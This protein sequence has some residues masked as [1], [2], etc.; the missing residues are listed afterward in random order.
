MDRWYGRLT[1]D[2]LV[3]EFRDFKLKVMNGDIVFNITNDAIDDLSEELD[4][5][6]DTFREDDILT[7]SIALR[8]FGLLHR[9]SSDI[10]ILIKDKNRYSEYTKQ[11][12]GDME[13]STPNRLG[14]KIFKYRPNIFSKNKEYE[15][16]FFEDIE[17]NFTEIEVGDFLNSRYIRIHNPIEILDL[18]IKMAIEGKSDKHNEDL[19]RIF[20]GTPERI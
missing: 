8:L 20:I 2:E 3:R 7:G 17:S 6:K 1:P 15:V 5:I 4:F 14:Y 16:D 11:K 12:Y 10:D 9:E 18:K 13:V 19:T